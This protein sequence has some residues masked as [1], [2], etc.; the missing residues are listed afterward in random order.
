MEPTA[1]AGL[2]TLSYKAWQELLA[3]SVSAPE[4]EPPIRRRARRYGVRLG[5]WRMLYQNGRKPAE[6]RVTLV[7]AA[8]DGVMLLSRAEVPENIP[9]LLAFTA[10]DD[11]EHQLVGEIVHC[12]STVGGYK[13]G[14]RL[15]FPAGGDNAR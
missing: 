1:P 3:C 14:V 8:L 7:N 15:R 9:T 12:T 4:F 5:A 2:A 10:D 11:E 6:L 13:V